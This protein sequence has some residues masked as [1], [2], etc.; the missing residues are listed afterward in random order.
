MRRKKKREARFKAAGGCARRTRERELADAAMWDRARDSTVTDS[1]GSEAFQSLWAPHAIG[2]AS[3]GVTKRMLS[4]VDLGEKKKKE[5]FPFLLFLS[6]HENCS[7]VDYRIAPVGRRDLV[8][9]APLTHSASLLNSFAF[10]TC[11]CVF[12]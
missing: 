2:F 9:L 5:I 6:L 8:A 10:S 3:D 12:R 4:L 11:V 1:G 7:F